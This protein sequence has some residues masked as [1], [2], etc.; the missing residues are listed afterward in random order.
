MR[1]RIDEPGQD[2]AAAGIEKIVWFAE[3]APVFDL[4]TDKHD[5]IVLAAHDRLRSNRQ[6]AQLRSASRGAPGRCDHLVGAV[7]EEA[8]PP[9]S[10]FPT[11]GL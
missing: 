9:F 5:A 3:L 2:T 8:H 7:N 4:V 6:D 11:A 10:E 1:M